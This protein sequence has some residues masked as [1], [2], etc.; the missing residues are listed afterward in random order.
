MQNYI[1]QNVKTAYQKLTFTIHK[2]DWQEYKKG[3][4][5]IVRIENFNEMKKTIIH[6]TSYI[7]M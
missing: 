1:Q 4:P 2:N 7:Y 3:M 6:V 5:T